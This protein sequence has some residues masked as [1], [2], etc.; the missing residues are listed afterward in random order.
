MTHECTKENQINQIGEQQGIV[1]DKLDGISEKLSL[2][3][4][5]QNEIKNINQMCVRLENW[6]KD[7]EHRLQD[8]EKAA[9]KVAVGV[10]KDVALL[11]IGAGF[12]WLVKG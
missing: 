8:L 6:L 12:A 11:A 4:V 2:V 7:H 9:G 3:L 5:Q 10:V 1:A